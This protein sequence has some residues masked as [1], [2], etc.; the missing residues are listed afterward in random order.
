MKK[1]IY[2]ILV[3]LDENNTA[4]YNT[5]SG[6]LGILNKENMNIYE[7]SLFDN[8]KNEKI[9]NEMKKNGFIVD[10]N[11]D[12]HEKTFIETQI[13]RYSNKHLYLT[14]CPTMDC[15]MNCPYCY[16]ENKKS[17]MNKNI[18]EKIFLFVSER[19][20]KKEIQKISVM[21]YGGE[22][23]LGLDIIL[24]LSKNLINLSQKNNI[25]YSSRIITNGYLLN[26]ET[27]L[28]LKNKCNIDDV[29]ITLDGPKNIHNKNRFTNEKI[30]SFDEI[31]ENI[32]D[33]KEILNVTI[34]INV[35]KKNYKEI[36]KLVDFLIE[37]RKWGDFLNLYFHPIFTEETNA[38]NVNE[39]DCFSNKEFKIFQNNIV[40]QLFNKKYLSI[41][42]DLYPSK[43]DISC[44]SISKNSFVID[45]EGFLYT[46][47]T[48]V[49]LPENSIGHIEKSLEINKQY[50]KW[51]NY[52]FDEECKKCISFPIC[53]GGCPSHNMSKSKQKHCNPRFSNLKNNLKMIC[54]DFIEKEQNNEL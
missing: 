17:Y 2:N 13:H 6:V 54:S 31:I 15:N 52:E 11:I 40:T 53:R 5:Y 36:P 44:G 47:T 48:F 9:I 32:E 3:N 46:C 39:K 27:A 41:I 7:N 8:K 43:I 42:K 28:I 49:G 33:I 34:R 18:V 51:L 12:E 26:K 38:C 29:Q 20:Q 25:E 1:S 16:E 4:I 30:G 22:P 14:I 23:L 24:N 45:S 50:S 35:D 19:I 10:S 21:W 37:N